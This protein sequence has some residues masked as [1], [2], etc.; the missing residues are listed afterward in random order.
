MSDAD[1]EP[2]HKH[3]WSIGGGGASE[4]KKFLDDTAASSLGQ[5]S[6]E[7]G[8]VCITKS[9]DFFS[10]PSHTF[11]RSRLERDYVR[12]FGSGEQIRD[13]VFNSAESVIF[14]YDDNIDTLSLDIVPRIARYRVAVQN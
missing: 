5:V 11:R 7:I 1:R 6:S 9:D 3:P 8:F 2:F 13:W 12:S 4:L 14:P 10:Q